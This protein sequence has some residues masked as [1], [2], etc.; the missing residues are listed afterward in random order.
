MSLHHPSVLDFATE[1][2]LGEFGTYATSGY[3]LLVVIPVEDTPD[4][5]ASI[6][7]SVD[8]VASILVVDADF[9]LQTIDP[10]TGVLILTPDGVA[11]LQDDPSLSV[12]VPDP[13]D[14]LSIV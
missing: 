3:F 13:E 2:L 12:M 1:G 5:I 6:V 14:Y 7:V 10:D 9:V 4:P 8:C 11:S